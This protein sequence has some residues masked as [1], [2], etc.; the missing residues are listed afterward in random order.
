MIIDVELL[1]IYDSPCG[2]DTNILTCEKKYDVKKSYISM[3][4]YLI[5]IY[6]PV[7]LVHISFH[8]NAPKKP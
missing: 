6:L 7:V 5:K 3:L 1:V 4:H 2:D 8:P